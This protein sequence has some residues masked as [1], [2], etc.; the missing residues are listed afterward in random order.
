MAI[1]KRWTIPFM[2]KAG[3][4]CHID[5]YQDEWTGSVTTLTGG[6][7]PIIY[8]E[9]DDKD[10]L[11]PI[12]YKTGYINIVEQNYGD[13]IDIYPDSDTSRYVEFY[14]GNRLDFTGYIQAS[15]YDNDFCAGPIVVSFPIISP[16]GLLANK[17]FRAI[18]SPGYRRIGVLLEEV[19]TGLGADGN[20]YNY[21]YESVVFPKLTSGSYGR[22]VPTLDAY[23]RSAVISPRDTD[24]DI[25]YGTV[26]DLYAPITYLDFMRALC[27]AFGWM[28]YD[29]PNQLVFR[30]V[31]CD[32]DYYICDT[33]SLA[34]PNSYQ[35]ILVADGAS[36]YDLTSYFTFRDNKAT[37]SHIRPKRRVTVNYDYTDIDSCSFDDITTV[38][39]TISPESS[40]FTP[41]NNEYES[42]TNGASLVYCS[43]TRMALFNLTSLTTQRCKLRFYNHPYGGGYM[44]LNIHLM[45]G[46]Y[47]EEMGNE[48]VF[49]DEPASFIEIGVSIKHRGLY[50]NFRDNVWQST[51]P[52]Y[53]SEADKGG[54]INLTI[55]PSSSSPYMTFV[56]D[57]I[58]EV[59]LRC[60]VP[61][62]PLPTGCRY[63]G[64]DSF[65]FVRANKPFIKNETF[66]K[67]F[68][69]SNAST[70]EAEVDQMFVTRSRYDCI[71]AILQKVT[72]YGNPESL[73]FLA[74][75]T[76]YAYMLN[77]QHRIQAKFALATFPQY[78]YIVKWQYWQTGWNWRMVA[79]SCNPVDDEYTLTL[80]HSPQ[81]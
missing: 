9:K 74:A 64:V 45:W 24:F 14:Y 60:A 69:G 75:L 12:R 51:L 48:D 3:V 19:I 58:I 66:K 33:D 50:Y 18:T 71:E 20:A 5:I 43:D 15:S 77:E 62:I 8:D 25:I 54:N 4:S 44:N 11:S 72:Q 65:E 41:I 37:M 29:T 36:V 59:E 68:E 1:G 61:Q 76:N 49:P 39:G 27:N 46:R 78:P 55:K 57:D 42:L 40:V 47:P 73:T 79:M 31:D 16:L 22:D 53:Y 52:F 7:T 21:A 67:V 80:H 38:M 32:G 81:F 17:R 26:S 13:L 6:D 63:V 30:R 35:T 56:Y 28:A 34:N 2:S 10:L 70:E 23:L